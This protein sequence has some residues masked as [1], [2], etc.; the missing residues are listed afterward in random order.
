MS[1]EPKRRNTPV[2]AGRAGQAG[3]LLL[4]VVRASVAEIGIGA[5][6]A[7]AGVAVDDDRGVRTVEAR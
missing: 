3:E 5:S 2:S 6:R 7:G 1:E 4:L